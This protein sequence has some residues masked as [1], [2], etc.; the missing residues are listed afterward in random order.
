MGQHPIPIKRKNDTETRNRN[1]WN[2]L[3]QEMV[4]HPMDE[5]MTTSSESQQEAG[6]LIK[7]LIG[8]KQQ[9]NIACW[10][11]RTLFQTGITR[12]LTNE[13]KRYKV[14]ICGISECR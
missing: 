6:S 4:A 9:M 1:Q 12:Q 11:V 13:F 3:V 8:P 2:T 14:D 5:R 7:P 10:N